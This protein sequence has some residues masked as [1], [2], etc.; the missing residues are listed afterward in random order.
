IY[1]HAFSLLDKTEQQT[2]M[3]YSLRKAVLDL[4]PS[5]FP[6]EQLVAE[7]FK[8]QGYHV[9]TDQIVKGYCAEHE[10]DVVAWRPAQDRHKQDL[11]MTEAKYH[12]QTELKSDLK[13]VLYVKA[14]FDDLEKMTYTYDGH[15]Y[16]LTEGWLVTNTKFTISA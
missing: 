4:G 9:L 6:F 13:I 12:G 7:M 8:A 3:R 2:A 10:V 1:K 14:R 5:G 16:S 11:I 15:A